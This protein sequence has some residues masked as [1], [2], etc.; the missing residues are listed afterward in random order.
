MTNPTP[1]T[2][3][4]A[5]TLQ[6]VI[7]WL[8]GGCDPK[9]AAKELRLLAAQPPAVAAPLSK[10]EIQDLLG[11]L[12]DEHGADHFEP[13]CPSCTAFQKLT[14]MLAQPPAGQQDSDHFPEAGK[15]MPAET[16][17]DE[18]P[19]R[20]RWVEIKPGLGRF[21][22]IDDAPSPAAPGNGEGGK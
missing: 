17:V 22:P 7:A 8:E 2:L 10:D 11:L 3:P 14:A 20:C 13:E 4:A 15:M 12:K 5:Q 21:I 1:Q 18:T 9:L 6:C 16:V 19:V